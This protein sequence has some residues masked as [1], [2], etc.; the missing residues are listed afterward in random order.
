MAPGAGRQ[1]PIF[2]VHAIPEYNGLAER[3][4][5]LRAVPF[6]EL[7]N[8]V[9][10]ASLRID[11]TETIQNRGFRLIQVRQPQHRLWDASAPLP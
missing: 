4:P 2:Q 8:G 7:L 10:V 5:R 1:M 11:R 6:D 3:E 9:P